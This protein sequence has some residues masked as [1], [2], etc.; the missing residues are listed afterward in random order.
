MD[1]TS[2]R[3]TWKTGLPHPSEK[4]DGT[5]GGNAPGQRDSLRLPIPVSHDASLVVGPLSP[6]IPRW[7]F[8]A[9][10]S[11]ALTSPVE[12]PGLPVQSPRIEI[13]ELPCPGSSAGLHASLKAL[14]AG[15][16]PVRAAALP[17]E[18]LGR[19][20]DGLIDQ[21][22]DQT[23]L[24]DIQTID[25]IVRLVEAF[26]AHPH[27]QRDCGWVSVTPQCQ[28]LRQSVLNLMLA[29]PL[30]VERGC[31]YPEEREALMQ[32]TREVRL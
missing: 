13:P 22:K 19:W 20:I 21:I 3:P 25:A 12:T 11:V 27:F 6:R 30:M 1:K 7:T 8:P 15:L 32:L 14:T 10:R 23:V 17:H 28:G 24:V 31:L 2:I 5:G 16:D 4:S 29:L 18:A 26:A 9:R